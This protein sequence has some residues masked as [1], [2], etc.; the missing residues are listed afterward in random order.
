MLDNFPIGK[1]SKKSFHVQKR[2]D[3]FQ[4]ITTA[5][6][7][8]DFSSFKLPLSQQRLNFF[9]PPPRTTWRAA[10]GT[11]TRSSGT[12]DMIGVAPGTSTD[13][14]TRQFCSMES[15]FPLQVVNQ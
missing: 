6:P 13:F 11:L 12:G 7:L 1:T 15:W 8:M 4:K 5:P 2:S 10:A 14:L 9:C 3:F